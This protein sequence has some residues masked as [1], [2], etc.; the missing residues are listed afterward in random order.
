MSFEHIHSVLHAFSLPS[1]ICSSARAVAW[2]FPARRCSAAAHRRSSST[3]SASQ[4][5]ASGSDKI[6]APSRRSVQIDLVLSRIVFSVICASSRAVIAFARP[7]NKKPVKAPC[8]EGKDMINSFSGSQTSPKESCPS[9]PSWCCNAGA[10][11]LR[12]RITRTS[13]QILFQYIQ[14]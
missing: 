10:V 3:E 11:F 8:V 9:S 5:P 13:S 4:K 1:V 14:A 6:G 7:P 2:I 12:S